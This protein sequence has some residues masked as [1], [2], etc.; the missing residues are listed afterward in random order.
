[1]S[2][3]VN[4]RLASCISCEKLVFQGRKC[5]SNSSITDCCMGLKCNLIAMKKCQI[6]TENRT[7]AKTSKSLFDVQFGKNKTRAL[8]FRPSR[9]CGRIRQ[10]T[11]FEL[12]VLLPKPKTIVQPFLPHFSSS[13][14]EL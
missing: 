12:I 1:M 2:N 6:H 10:R 14:K 11:I 5:I 8:Y 4:V 3:R 7:K 13:S 9:P